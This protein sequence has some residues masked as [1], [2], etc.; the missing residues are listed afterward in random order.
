[1]IIALAFTWVVVLGLYWFGWQLF[2]QNGR[3]LLRLEALE[4]RLDELDSPPA[5]EGLPVGS[6]APEFDLPDLTGERRTLAQFRA[7]PL[8]VV[9]FNPDCGFCRD[10]APKLAALATRSSRREGAHTPAL[11]HAD[12]SLLTSAATKAVP[13]VLVIATGD[14]EKNRQFFAEHKMTS[15]VLLQNDSE[16]ATAYQANG[17]PT[18]YLVNAEGKIASKLVLGSEA[19]LALVKAP[20][21][22]PSTLNPQPADDPASRFGNRSLARSKIARNGLKAGT[23]A[24]LFRLPRL[25]GGELALDDLRGNRVLLVFSDPHCGPCEALAPLLE[26]SHREHPELRVVMISRGDPKE[27]RAKVKAHGLTF[28]VVLQQHWEISRRYAMFA[29]PIAYLIDETGVITHDVAVGEDAIRNLLSE[30]RSPA[31]DTHLSPSWV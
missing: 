12:Q 13:L 24:P 5:P 8:L 11:Q 22:Q 2:R 17:T 20:V 10:L 14:A 15:P 30:V 6:L 19:L 3:L 9:F 28:P 29:A 16:V 31:A 7:Q 27:N 18:G 26:Q 23:P 21:P 4:Q 25:D 1:M